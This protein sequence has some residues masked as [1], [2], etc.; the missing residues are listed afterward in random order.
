MLALRV[1]RE[2]LTLLRRDCA[3]LI[4]ALEEGEGASAEVARFRARYAATIGG[5]ARRPDRRDIEAIAALLEALAVDVS[6]CLIAEEKEEK[7]DGNAAQ[8]DRHKQNSNPKP[9]VYE[10]AAEPV[11]K[12]SVEFEPAIGSQSRLEAPTRAIYPLGL[13]LDSCPDIADYARQGIHT[14]GDL[15]DVAGLVRTM[16]G[17]SPHAWDEA[18]MVMGEDTAAVTVA[19][20]LQRAEHIKSPGGY[21]RTLVER[22]RAGQYSLGPVLQALNRARLQELRA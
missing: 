20:I 18:K 9:T 14:W 10:P 21:L 22:K 2:R 13:V 11:R 6:K 4:L 5:L 19:A 7:M 8:N 17:I 3:K 1:A 16:L 12:A 15:I